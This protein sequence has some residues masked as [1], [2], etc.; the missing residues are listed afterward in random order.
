M[1]ICHNMFDCLSMGNLSVYPPNAFIVQLIKEVKFNLL[2]ITCFKSY[3][4]AKGKGTLYF[5]VAPSI[6]VS[7]HSFF[8]W[9]VMRQSSWLIVTKKN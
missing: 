9:G 2:L 7:L 6:L 3:R 4:W 5:K 8:F 1:T